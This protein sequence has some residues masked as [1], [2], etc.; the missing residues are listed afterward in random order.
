M[1]GSWLTTET[2]DSKTTVRNKPLGLLAAAKTLFG[3]PN[4]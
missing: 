3:I 4:S 1:R 2:Y